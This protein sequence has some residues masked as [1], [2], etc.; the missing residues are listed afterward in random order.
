MTRPEAT[1]PSD[2]YLRAARFVGEQAAGRAYRALEQTI[3]TAEPNDLSVYR[4]KLAGVYHVAVVGMRPPPALEERLTALLRTGTPTELPAAVQQA[5]LAR[6]AQ[7]TPHGEWWEG[8]YRP[9]RRL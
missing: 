4:L 1:P 8:H 5:L 7:V 2:P 6:R 3:Y 9:G